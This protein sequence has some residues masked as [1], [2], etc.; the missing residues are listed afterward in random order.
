MIA[1]IREHPTD[2]ALVTIDVNGVEA[3]E[4]MGRFAPARLSKADRVYHLG[5]GAFETFQRFW[6]LAGGQVVDERGRGPKATPGVG[7]VEPLPECANCGQPR[8]RHRSGAD[9]ATHTP[10]ASCT[11]CAVRPTRC[12][13]CGELWVDRVH[14]PSVEA[15]HALG[16][17]CAGCG[18]FQRGYGRFCG[19]CGHEL[20]PAT[21]QDAA[22]APPQG[23]REWVDIPM[24][25]AGLAGALESTVAA[26]AVGP[27]Q[28]AINAR[29]L[30]QVRASIVMAALVLDVGLAAAALAV[31]CPWCDSPP[32]R[33]C[34]ND[35]GIRQRGVHRI[36]AARGAS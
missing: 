17:T 14:Q 6:R 36:R 22:A 26:A 20:T 21:R 1:T 27:E 11:G 29:G 30:A 15:S 24:S 12:P 18:K 31:D 33:P 34:L 3:N 7:M 13:G 8:R 32:G 4:T 19:G 16:A 28:R 2:P 9:P 35:H 23:H 5:V 25:A 10:P